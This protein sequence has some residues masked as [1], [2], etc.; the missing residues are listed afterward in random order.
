MFLN[1]I[2]YV[3]K[4]KLNIEWPI[5]SFK[6]DFYILKVLKTSLEIKNLKT[7][8]IAKKQPLLKKKKRPSCWLSKDAIQS[9]KNSRRS[10]ND[11]SNT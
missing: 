6:M 3:L 2:K 8:K 10:K 7:T 9:T 5:Y 4:S 11:Y 1:F